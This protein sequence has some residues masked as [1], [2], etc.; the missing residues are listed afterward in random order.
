[1]LALLSLNALNLLLLHKYSKLSFVSALSLKPNEVLW[2]KKTFQQQLSLETMETNSAR[3]L[4]WQVYFLYYSIIAKAEN[5][6]R[7][8]ISDLKQLGFT[9]LLF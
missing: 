4:K 6:S 2:C 1:M 3:L 9:S 5:F 8:I 7:S